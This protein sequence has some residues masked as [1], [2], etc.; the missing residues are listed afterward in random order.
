MSFL[1]HP[2]QSKVKV[3][4]RSI[5]I[6]YPVIT[7]LVFRKAIE[8]QLLPLSGFLCASVS[9]RPFHIRLSWPNVLNFLLILSTI[10]ICWGII[11]YMFQDLLLFGG[12]TIISIYDMLYK[13]YRDFTNIKLFQLH[14]MTIDPVMYKS[15]IN[16]ADGY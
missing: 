10:H 3:F 15:A 16:Y 2:K 4:F 7:S 6:S 14:C 1:F 12:N 8:Y 9:F 11:P 5:Y 13:I